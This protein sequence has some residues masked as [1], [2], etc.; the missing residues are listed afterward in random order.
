MFLSWGSM[1]GFFILR[2]LQFSGTDQCGCY[3]LM[4]IGFMDQYHFINQFGTARMH[5]GGSRSI[6]LEAVKVLII[7]YSFSYFS[8]RQLLWVRPYMGESSLLKLITIMNL[9]D[10]YR[11]SSK[12]FSD[13]ALYFQL[14]SFVVK[15]KLYI[16]AVFVIKLLS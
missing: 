14:K 8:S 2:Y 1:C 4:V 12:D 10:R 6:W 16:F 7:L 3:I 9:K 13:K 5:D 11:H 15:L